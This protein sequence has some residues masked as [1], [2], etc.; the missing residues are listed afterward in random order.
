LLKRETNSSIKERWLKMMNNE[1]NTTVL[2]AIK[3][4]ANLTKAESNESAGLM[5]EGRKGGEEESPLAH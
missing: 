1:G 2:F 5:R 4:C 3:L